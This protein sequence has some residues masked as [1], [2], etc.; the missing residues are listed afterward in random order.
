[1]SELAA[2][3]S[4]NRAQSVG[5]LVI[6]RQVAFIVVDGQSTGRNSPGQV[7]VASLLH[8][9]GDLLKADKAANRSS[10]P[11]MAHGGGNPTRAGEEL[12]EVL[13]GLGSDEVDT[14][15]GFTAALSFRLPCEGGPPIP[16]V[17]HRDRDQHEHRGTQVGV[18]SKSEPRKKAHSQ[19][20]ASAGRKTTEHEVASGDPA[21]LS[22]ASSAAEDTKGML[23]A[24]DQRKTPEQSSWQVRRKGVSF[25]AGLGS[26]RRRGD[27]SSSNGPDR[28]AGPHELSAASLEDQADGGDSCA[29]KHEEG[30]HPV[31]P[32]GEW[33]TV[34]PAERHAEATD[35]LAAEV[36]RQE[37]V[38]RELEDLEKRLRKVAALRIQRWFRRSEVGLWRERA[39]EHL[40][41]AE[42]QVEEATGGASAEAQ[43]FRAEAEPDEASEAIANLTGAPTGLS[44]AGGAHKRNKANKAR[45]K[46]AKQTTKARIDAEVVSTLSAVRVKLKTKHRCAPDCEHLSTEDPVGIQLPKEVSENPRLNAGHLEL[47]TRIAQARQ[48]R[49]RGWLQAALCVMRAYAQTCYAVG[50]PRAQAISVVLTILEL[51]LRTDGRDVG[52]AC[53]LVP[54]MGSSLGGEAGSDVGVGGI[55]ATKAGV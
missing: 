36:A 23:T 15:P 20:A 53:P 27:S 7:R 40:Q 13:R 44:V 47:A 12:D 1:M 6:S 26:E 16:A 48:K 41:P 22:S 51:V 43:H 25:Q 4:E 33:E 55:A 52:T 14:W 54:Q 29:L 24:L 19:E 10:L 38:G 2:G 37:A 18:T 5:R 34:G 35:V 31:G 11:A 42:A 21:A 30:P 32:R 50:I 45:K 49:G 28:G 9:F 39:G 8:K 3:A 17:G 46:R